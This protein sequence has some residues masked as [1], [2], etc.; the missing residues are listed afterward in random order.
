[1]RLLRTTTLAAHHDGV[2]HY[3]TSFTFQ[4]AGEDFGAIVPLPGV[5]TSIERGGNW[6]LQRLEREKP[7]PPPPPARWSSPVTSPVTSPTG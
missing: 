5:P 1:V 3:V 6:T 4:G 2:E 7:P